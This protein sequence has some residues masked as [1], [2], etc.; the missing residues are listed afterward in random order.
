M[1]ADHENL[2]PGI[3]AYR[4]FLPQVEVSPPYS[5]DNCS[6]EHASDTATLTRVKKV[7]SDLQMHVAV[8]CLTCHAPVY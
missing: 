6:T 3:W 7:V 8:I 2:L 4:M 5:L 1:Q